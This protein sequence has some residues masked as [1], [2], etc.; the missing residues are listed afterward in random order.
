VSVT[1]S[2]DQPFGRL[3]HLRRIAVDDL[4]GDDLVDHQVQP[5]VHDPAVD[6]QLVIPALDCILER[7]VG[8]ADQNGTLV[9]VGRIEQ[10]EVPVLG[11]RAVTSAIIKRRNRCSDASLGVRRRHAPDGSG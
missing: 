10:P 9:Q 5:R 3:E 1:A 11:R 4:G 8:Q 2:R 6:D 7:G